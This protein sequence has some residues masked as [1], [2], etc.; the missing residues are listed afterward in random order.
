MN[1]TEEFLYYFFLPFLRG[2]VS[3]VTNV[4]EQSLLKFSFPVSLKDLHFFFL[5]KMKINNPNS[6]GN[7]F[8]I[9]V[10]HSYILIP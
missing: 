8:K 5:V 9:L 6:A 3:T 1:V 2:R 7:V 10:L 4:K